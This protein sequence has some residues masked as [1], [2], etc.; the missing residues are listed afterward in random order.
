MTLTWPSSLS[1]NWNIISAASCSFT[2]CSRRRDKRP[3]KLAHRDTETLLYKRRV[4]ALNT[5]FSSWK[6]KSF[7]FFFFSNLLR[8]KHGKCAQD[9]KWG[10]STEFVIVPG[11][12]SVYTLHFIFLK[13]IFCFL[14][15]GDTCEVSQASLVTWRC[16]PGCKRLLCAFMY[17][18]YSQC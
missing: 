12:A 4:H 2:P 18:I 11:I 13:A 3:N 8:A 16:M 1:S 10:N 5:L 17:S 6:S 15:L 7:Y 9:G 14:A